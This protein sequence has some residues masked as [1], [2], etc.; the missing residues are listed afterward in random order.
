MSQMK[1]EKPTQGSR[2]LKRRALKCFC[3]V[4]QAFV[5]FAH[6]VFDFVVDKVFSWYYDDSKRKTISKVAS[7]LL[8]ES[9]VQL[10]EKIRRR[11]VSAV[12][13]VQGFIDRIREVNP[14]INAVV[15]DRFEVAL[16]EA[17]DVEKL[18]NS[19]SLTPEELKKTKPFLGVPFTTKDST[20]AKD[21]LH[22]LG[23]VSRKS[24]LAAEDA[25]AVKQMKEAGAILIGTTNVPELNMWCETRNN[26]FGQTL[27]PYDTRRTVGGSSGG[28]GSIVATCG[29]PLGLASDIGGSIRI[30]AFC[31][32]VFG[33]KPT[34]GITPS[35]GFTLRTGK[36]KNSMMCVGPMCRFSEELA[37]FLK[38]IVGPNADKLQLDKQVSVEDVQFFYVEA[39]GDLRASRVGSDARD[40]M[41]RAVSH[42]SRLSKHPVQKISFPELRYS[43]RLWRYWMSKEPAVFEE[44][45]ANREGKVCAWQEILK[46]LI[47]CSNFTLAALIRLVDTKMP[48]ENPQWAEETT[49]SLFEKIQAKLG[50]NGVLLYPSSPFPAP[51]HFS[52]FLRPYNFGYWAVFNVLNLPVTQVPMGLNADGLPLG[53]Q[54]VAGMH[55]DHLCFAVAKELE[56]SFGGWVPPFKC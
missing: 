16:R 49:K 39:S 55:Q 47:G 50:N 15:C 30:P 5:V 34:T 4:L 17:Q 56:K 13:V 22:T 21:M 6:S 25:D 42:F 9:A 35:K 48:S 26:V 23:L 53:L 20:A 19:G 52:S 3:Q 10:A 29:S 54:V 1:F 18:V 41:L 2:S 51:Y 38:I 32:G 31:C 12:D 28:E 43:F 27:N 36:E 11:E 45:L 24:A 7:P 8:L 40:T 33:H 37:Q 14:V 46:K 44:D